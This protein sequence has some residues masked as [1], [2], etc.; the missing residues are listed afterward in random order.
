MEQDHSLYIDIGNTSLD[1]LLS[2]SQEKAKISWKEKEA[3][4]KLS[5]FLTS[6]IQK[7]YI[8]SVSSSALSLVQ[9]C[10]E[11]KKIPYHVLNREDMKHFATKEKYQIDNLDILGS[12][13]FCDL[14]AEKSSLGQI[15]IDLGTASKILY[16]DQNK[17]FYG[18][19]IFP[20]PLTF[21]STLNLD[22]DLLK[23]YPLEEGAPLISLKT[24]ES[25]SSGETNGVSSLIAGVVLKIKQEY[26]DPQ[27]Q[28][29]LTGGNRFLV[30]KRL[31]YFGLSQ[32]IVKENMVLE[33]LKRI[34][35]NW[36]D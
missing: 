11:E 26:H 5:V 22:T 33:G 15:L 12:D 27:V 31:A 9:D 7:A 32:V 4:N 2:D 8:S 29:Y 14:V 35:Q 13:L 17:R 23:D 36:E 3:R 19:M 10:L 1:L 20:S 6:Q 28:I 16:L 34:Y 25:I 18:G 21:A 24:A 30:E